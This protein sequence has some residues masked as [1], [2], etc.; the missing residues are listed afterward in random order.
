MA[1]ITLREQEGKP[2][3]LVLHC[4]PGTQVVGQLYEY[5]RL[6]VAG[7]VTPGAAIPKSVRV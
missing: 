7:Y 4:A 3:L 2:V 6:H 5:L 1:Y